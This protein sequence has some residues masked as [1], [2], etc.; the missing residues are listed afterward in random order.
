MRYCDIIVLPGLFVDFA[1]VRAVA[2]AGSS[3][4][5]IGHDWEE[6]A[7][8]RLRRSSRCW[9]WASIEQSIVWNISGGKD[10]TLHEVNEAAEV[11]AIVGDSVDYL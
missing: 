3:L 7:G 5:G 8:Q 2:D 6:Q 1:D 9:I 10:L 4:M 11:I